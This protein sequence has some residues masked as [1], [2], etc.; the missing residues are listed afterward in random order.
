MFAS[1]DDIHYDHYVM[2]INIYMYIYHMYKE[3]IGRP[4]S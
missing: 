2:H 3:K 4:I 1:D